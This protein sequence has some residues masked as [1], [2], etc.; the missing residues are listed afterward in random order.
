[1]AFNEAAQDLLRSRA[2]EFFDRGYQR[3]TEGKL[4]PFVERL[5]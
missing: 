1:M 2:K 4:L 5:P 3:I